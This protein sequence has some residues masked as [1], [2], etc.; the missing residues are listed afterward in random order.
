MFHLS[1]WPIS[2]DIRQWAG[3]IQWNYEGSLVE[4]SSLLL[5]EIGQINAMTLNQTINVMQNQ[6]PKSST[7]LQSW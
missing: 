6:R 5:L 7:E 3:S 2:S 4:I 1:Q